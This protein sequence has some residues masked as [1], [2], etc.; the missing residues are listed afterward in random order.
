MVVGFVDAALLTLRQAIGVIMCANIG[1]TV[2]GWIVS[3]FGFKFDITSAALPAVAVGSAMLPI[4]NIRRDDIAH[5]LIGFGFLFLGLSLLKE[6][7]PDIRN[8]P[9]LL[10]FLSILLFVLLGTI[11]TVVVQ[12]S[13]AAMAITLTMTFS[14]WIDYPT[15]A[16][17]VLGENIGTTLTAYLA[18]LNAGRNARR[19]AVVH[20]LFNVF[21]VIWIAV[22][23]RPALALV[24]VIVPGSISSRT[25]I[26]A[27]LAMFHTLFNVSNTAIC[28]G[29]VPFFEKIVHYLVR[30]EDPV[31][32]GHYRLPYVRTGLQ[33]T[34]QQGSSS[35]S[36]DRR[37]VRTGC[38]DGR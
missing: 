26:T 13:S 9:E 24:D 10:R 32:A 36:V 34:V 18:S 19:A 1:T 28:I 23:F 29:F 12:S 20:T 21:G 5:A 16:A 2:T 27:H 7:V 33:D 14:G 37:G 11:L 3:L 22:L 8:N 4:K 25:E 31:D 6:S 15:A 17:I 30:G 38:R 35:R